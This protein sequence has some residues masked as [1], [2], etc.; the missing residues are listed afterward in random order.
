ME[1]RT[2]N[3]E[4]EIENNKLKIANVILEDSVNNLKY[5]IMEKNKEILKL[6]K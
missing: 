6:E 3:Q 2:K 1:K 4:L 5:I